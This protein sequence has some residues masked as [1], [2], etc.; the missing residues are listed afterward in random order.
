M[1]KVQLSEERAIFTGVLTRAT[2]TR[3]FDKKYRKLVDS[4]KVTLD[5]ANV[6]QVDTAGLAWTLRLIELAIEKKCVILL[7]NMSDDFIKLAKLSGVDGFL[8]NK[9]H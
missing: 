2:I 4:E 5:F 6:S 8:P 9:A 3:A 1:I 7:S